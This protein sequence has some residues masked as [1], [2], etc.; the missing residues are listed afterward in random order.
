MAIGRLCAKEMPL[1]TNLGSAGVTRAFVPIVGLL[2]I[3]APAAALAQATNL[4]QGKSASQIF[5]AACIECHKAPHGLAKGKS[6]DTVAEFLREHYTTSREQAAALAA[7]VVGGRDSVA[8]P[9]PGKRQP[10]ERPSAATEEPKPDKRHRAKPEEGASTNARREAKPADDEG[11][12]ILPGILSPA[13]PEREV[14]PPA[15]TRNRRKDTPPA[16]TETPQEPA[17]TARVPAAAPVAEPAAKPEE[18]APA[19]TAKAP[20]PPANEPGDS[21][22][23]DNVPD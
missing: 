23:R 16:A 10:A 13:K 17:S 14:K 11:S 1:H 3:L 15:T 21:V 5:S 6:V 8:N 7:F 9:S 22:P 2:S 18:S 19:P 12:G 4:D 20:E